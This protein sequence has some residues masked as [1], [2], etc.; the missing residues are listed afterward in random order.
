MSKY[1]ELKRK[2]VEQCDDYDVDDGCIEFKIRGFKY[3]CTEK[4][5]TTFIDW[6]LSAFSTTKQ[7][8]GW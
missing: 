6:L 7:Q 5:S 2:V 4:D 3:I 8:G 1:E